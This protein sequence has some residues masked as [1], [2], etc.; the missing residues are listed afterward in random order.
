MNAC[1]LRRLEAYQVKE[2]LKM[3]EKSLRK[4]FGVREMVFRRGTSAARLREI[5]E[6]RTRSRKEN[7]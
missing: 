6:V 3:L 5:E 2:N 7:I 1:K 4:R